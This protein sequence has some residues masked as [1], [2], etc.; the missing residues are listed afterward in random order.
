MGRGARADS[1]KTEDVSDPVRIGVIGAGD[2]DDRVAELAERVGREIARA[3][4]VLY[5]GG[6]GGVMEAA[7]RGARAEGGVTIGILPG[8]F[9]RDANPFI[10]HPVVTG[11]DQARNVVLV[12]SCE[13]IVAVGGGYGTLSEIALA[14]KMG[15]PVV[16]VETWRLDEDR[17]EPVP[18]ASGAR[19]AV[20]L[21]ISWARE[22]GKRR[23][24][25]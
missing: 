6:L 25:R 18:Q 13:A 22:G 20:A 21:A 12:R 8:F 7:A 1:T 14:R 16:G 24:R 3:G 2:A 19:E 9:A 5:C 10:T 23:S 17:G 15:V 4:A 11:M